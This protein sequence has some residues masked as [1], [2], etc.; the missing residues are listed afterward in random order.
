M[1]RALY[2]YASYPPTEY[3]LPQNVDFFTFNVYLHHQRDFEKYL[4]RLQN[5]ADDKPLVLGEFG[6]DTI[7]HREEEQAEMLS[8]HVD[9]VVRCG[10]AGAV[11]YAWTDEWFTGGRRSRTGRSVSSRATASPRNPS[12]RSRPNRAATTRCPRGYCRVPQGLRH[13]LLLQRREHAGQLPR[14][15]MKV[16]YP[17]YEVILVDDGSTDNT[18]EIAARYPSI[19]NIRQKNRA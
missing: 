7:R 8:W 15:V 5:L 9:S 19:V 6:M 10:L 3:L 1:I 18:Q 13:R 11:V 2:S 17:D 14:L 4:L 16:N 12:R